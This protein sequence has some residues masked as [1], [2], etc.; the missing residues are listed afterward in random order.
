[1]PNGF[2]TARREYALAH[3]AM[4]QVDVVCDCPSCGEDMLCVVYGA[5]VEIDA[6][7]INGCSSESGF[8]RDA[9]NSAAYAIADR[10]QRER[11]DHEVHERRRGW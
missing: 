9:L 10:E 7:C 11:A 1:M 8:D 2:A 6:P 4:Y 3:G 5:D